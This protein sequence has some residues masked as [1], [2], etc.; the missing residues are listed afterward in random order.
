MPGAIAEESGAIAEDLHDVFMLWS[1]WMHVNSGL[2]DAEQGSCWKS[3]SLR[4]CTVYF[5]VNVLQTL[6]A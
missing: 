5:H 1:A 4:K 3:C 2:K 6:S